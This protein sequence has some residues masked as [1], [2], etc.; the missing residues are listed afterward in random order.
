MIHSFKIGLLLFTEK[1][2]P[3]LIKGGQKLISNTLELF[4]LRLRLAQPA[5]ENIAPNYQHQWIFW[6]PIF[7]TALQTS[8]IESGSKRKKTLKRWTADNGRFVH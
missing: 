8:E 7:L 5:L 6:G 3:F 4:V 2:L 1:V